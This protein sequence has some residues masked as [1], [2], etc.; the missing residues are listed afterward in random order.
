[1]S[2]ADLW[3]VR[4]VVVDAILAVA[5]RWPSHKVAVVEARLEKLRELARWDAEVARTEWD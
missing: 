5:S 3:D 2:V 1:M 4:V